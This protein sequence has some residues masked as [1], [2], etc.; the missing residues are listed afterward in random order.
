MDSLAQGESPIAPQESVVRRCGP[1]RTVL[2]GSAG[3]GDRRGE[4]ATT[5]GTAAGTI[6]PVA[7]SP[8]RPGRA[9]EVVVCRAPNRQNPRR[10]AEARHA[11]EQ[12]GH[13]DL[14]ADPRAPRPR[15]QSWAT[16]LCSHAHE[17][18]TCD[19]LPVTDL[20]S[21][22]LFAYFVVAL[23]CR[24]VVHVG[25]TR[26]P[27]MDDWVARQLREAT[28]FGKRP[29]L[30]IRNNDAKYGAQCDQVA[31]A[32][33]IRTLRTPVRA[34][35]ANATCARF[36]QERA[37]RVPRPHARPRRAPAR[38][39]APR[40]RRV[41]QPGAVTPGHWPS[42]AGA[43]PRR[44]AQPCRAGAR[45]AGARRPPPHLPARRV[46]ALDEN[47]AM[48]PSDWSKSRLRQARQPLSLYGG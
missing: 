40:V 32:S 22:P 6:V 14:L 16:F 24:R 2:L 36:L 18:W 13:P 33:G 8:M 7:R 12:A 46:A 25:V 11:R 47:V 42:D 29:R 39:G 48:T 44:D 3:A 41:F 15:G 9:R 23:G 31:A 38:A 20:C 45:H 21:R 10:A 35:R 4:A 17:I 27:N 19:F 1:P 30:L 5:S 28:P 37:P 34:P 26:H 43:I